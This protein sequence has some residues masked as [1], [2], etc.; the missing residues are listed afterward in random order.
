MKI[1]GVCGRIGSGKDEFCNRLVKKY[2]FV[3]LIMSD[4]VN[5]E[6]EKRGL[7]VSR[8]NQQK[9]S[10][11]YKEKYGRKGKGEW[12]RRT[13]E[14]ARKNSL[15]R[16]VVSGVRDSQE[17]E[18]F[19]KHDFTLILVTASPETRFKRLAA[20]GSRKDIPDVEALKV[21]EKKEA[22]VFDIY[23]RFEEVSDFTIQNN[24]T[25]EELYKKTDELMKKLL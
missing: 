25:L 4:R 22:V 9:V 6:L 24:G 20:R 2:G 5:E 17:L 13:V 8:E 7:P 19:K 15:E 1:I 16:I 10:L 14:Y 12:A 18:V 3:K 23:D 11:E 21:Q